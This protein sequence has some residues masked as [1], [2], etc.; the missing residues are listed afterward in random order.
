MTV[1]FHKANMP[2]G[3]PTFFMVCHLFGG[4]VNFPIL[5]ERQLLAEDVGRLCDVVDRLQVQALATFADTDMDQAALCVD[6]LIE[7]DALRFVLPTIIS[8]A[9]N[10]AS[11]C[12]NIAGPAQAAAALP[13]PPQ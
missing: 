1:G 2:F 4:G 13:A 11:A 12:D 10:Y 9:G 3:S 8:A 5:P 6:A 7:N